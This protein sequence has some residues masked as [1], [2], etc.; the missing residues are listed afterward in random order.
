MW[1]YNTPVKDVALTYLEAGLAP[2]P[3]IPGEKRPPIEWTKYQQRPPK[4]EEVEEWFSNGDVELGVLTG[5]ASNG[6][7]VERV[8]PSLAQKLSDTLRIKTP[9][10][11]HL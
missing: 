5:N 3:L 7:A 2:I 8:C 4:R 9:R 10:G 1:N 6:L 11:R